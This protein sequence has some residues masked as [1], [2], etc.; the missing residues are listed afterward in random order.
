MEA[1]YKLWE[2]SWED[3][4]VLRDRASRPFAD[5]GKIHRVRHDGRHFKVDAI[6]L[7]EPS[8]QRTPVLYQ[9][10]ASTRGRAFAAKH[11]ECVFINGPS[12][13]VVGDIVA[14][15]P[16]PCR[17]RGRDPADLMIFTMMTVITG[18]T[19]EAAQEK[20]RDYLRMSARTARWR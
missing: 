9:A 3:G 12:K 19:R 20:Y 17:R 10:G 1:V 5:A 4:A 14:R 8:P 2:A 13:K 18:P 6:H 11:A 16:P 15:H 7:C